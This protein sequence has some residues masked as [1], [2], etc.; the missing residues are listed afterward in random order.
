MHV[1]A[2]GKGSPQRRVIAH[3]RKETELGLAQISVHEDTVGGLWPEVGLHPRREVLRIRISAREPPSVRADYLEI[4]RSHTSVGVNMFTDRLAV[5][6]QNLGAVPKVEQR[7][8]Q[9][10]TNLA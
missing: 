2:P 9:V 7:L 3:L 4:L 10:A 5:G 6:R 8:T 1:F